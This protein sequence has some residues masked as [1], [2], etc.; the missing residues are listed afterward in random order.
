M[1]TN[2]CNPGGGGV[3]ASPLAG[4]RGEVRAAGAGP[5]R[6]AVVG[7]GVSGLGAAW[8]LDLQHDVTVYEQD[9]RLGGHVNTVS[10][11]DSAGEL[12][13]DTG[14]IVFNERNYPHL[15]ALFRHLGVATRATDMS[16]AATI[17]QGRVEYAGDNLNALFGQ[18][19]N[20]VNWRHWRMVAQ[21]LRFNRHA[22]RV[23]D[24][25]LLEDQSLGE[26]LAEGGYSAELRDRYLM[27]MGAAIWSCPVEEMQ[28]FPA[29]AFLRF[30]DNHGLLTLKDR[31]QWRTVIGGSREYVRKLID[32]LRGVV[33]TDCAVTGVRRDRDGVTVHDSRGGACRYDH[34]VIATHADQALRLLDPPGFW[35][36]TVLGA[37]RYQRNR[38]VLHTDPSLMPR[39]PRVWS[40]WNYIGEPG[41]GNAG[42]SVSVTYWM[43]RLQRLPGR[44]PYLVT[45]N[46]SR[47]PRPDRVIAEF[48]YEHPVFDQAAG[49]AQRLLERVQGPDRTWFCG[50]YFGYGFHEDGL[51]S[52]IEVA[53]R[54]GIDPPWETT[55]HPGQQPLR[56]RVDLG[57]PAATDAVAASVR[58]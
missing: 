14:F 30:F 46:P 32:S 6:I 52:G 54:F 5:L 47:E 33:R 34:V 37:F 31:P 1:M 27:P 8:L 4:P 51:R 3:D 2:P 15:A 40:S 55:Q 20:L 56:N 16:F 11:A 21:I 44:T 39:N 36:Q 22:R 38:A 26:F 48:E 13:V 23:L 53:R 57:R 25:P 7:T 41:T 24:D 10:V 28:S 42:N 50:A 45:L 18:R 19:R 35:E 17:D 49:R 12:G 9:G 58:G 29:S 43:N